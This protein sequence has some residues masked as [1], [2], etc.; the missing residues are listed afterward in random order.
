MVEFEDIKIG[1]LTFKFNQPEKEIVVDIP[2]AGGIATLTSKPIN[3]STYEVIVKIKEE[4]KFS[5]KTD[6]IITAIGSNTN[7]KYYKLLSGNLEKQG[8]VPDYEGKNL[9]GKV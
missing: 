6:K 1:Q 3:I 4:K 5:F 8:I 9:Q 2:I 7:N